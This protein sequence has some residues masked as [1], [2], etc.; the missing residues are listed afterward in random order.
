M[1]TPTL[2]KH[3]VLSIRFFLEQP[4]G[5]DLSDPGTGKTRVQI[6]VFAAR[7]KRG[8]KCALVIAPK[9]LLHSAWQDD[10]HKFAPWIKTSVCP[11]DKRAAGFAADAD[12]Y[13]TNT[14]A[15]RW[16]AEQPPRFFARFDTLIV[17]E[18]SSFKHSTSK[19]SRALAKIRKYFTFRYG[20][21]GTPNANSITDIWHPTFII[22]DGKR[23]GS[24]FFHFR[25]A[26]CAPQQVGPRPEMVKWVDKPGAEAAVS[27]LL[28][29]IVIRHRFEDCIDIPANH[30]YTMTYHLSP[31][32]QAAY[33]KMERDAVLSIQDQKITA[34]NAAG[35]L[36]K[37]L[38]IA[39]GA[40]YDADG[41]YALIDTGR[42]EMAV[43][44]IEQRHDPVL[45]FFNWAHQKEELERELKAREITYAVLDGSVTSDNERKRIVDFFQA[46]F[47]RVLLAHPQSAAHGLT[48]VRA[49]TT[50]WVSPTYNLEHWLQGNRRVYRAGQT[51]KTETIMLIAANTIEEKVYAKL[52][53][54]NARQADLLA[55]LQHS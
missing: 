9:S 12:V 49:A 35:V 18:I 55:L 28:Q 21:T 7:R 27:G 1:T 48:L 13:I 14:D 54:K 42:Y 11:A 52:Q 38:Q 15:V 17:D 3:Q 4:R 20:L 31:R 16:L 22:D 6:E 51:R 2:F 47:Y 53:D 44:L 41:E 32:Q 30:Q 26:V 46:G 25:S 39:S 23:L 19:R 36:G 5:L 8:G 37:L 50:L 33:L 24:S 40:A 29:D 34:I 43:D 10:F 45:V